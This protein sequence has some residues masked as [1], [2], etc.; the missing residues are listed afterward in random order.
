MDNNALAIKPTTAPAKL[1]GGNEL[2][3][4]KQILT[5]YLSI[6][7]GNVVADLGAGGAAYFTMQSARLVGETGQVYAVDVIKN[8]LSGIESK[9]QMSGLYNIKTVWSNLE[10]VGATK[11]PEASVDFAFLINILF[12]TPKKHE[13]VNEAIRLLKPG[14][15]LLIIDWNDNAL[16][17]SPAANL[18]VNQE[19]I[20]KHAEKMSLTLQQRFDAG[21]H[22]FGLIFVK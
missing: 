21:A 6:K 22:H 9:A 17:F 7:P 1:S 18:R 12:Q 3:D 15:H 20:I 11:I 16:S 5:Q 19:D 2:L 10:I 4:A 14:G 13:V 8:V